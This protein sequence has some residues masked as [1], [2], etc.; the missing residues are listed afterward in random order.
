MIIELI[1]LKIIVKLL[2]CV[3]GIQHGCQDMG[4]GSLLLLRY[5]TPHLYVIHTPALFIHPVINSLSTEVHSFHR[6]TMKEENGPE[7]SVKS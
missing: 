5:D 6:N 2:L 7:R 4:A 3:S 1:W